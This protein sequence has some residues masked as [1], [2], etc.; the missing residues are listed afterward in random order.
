MAKIIDM[1]FLCESV[2]TRSN[3]MVMISHPKTALDR[4][5]MSP[6][7]KL[8]RISGHTVRGWLRHAAEKLLIQHGV[9]ICHPLAKISVTN[10][11]NKKYYAKDLEL[12]YHPR[13]ECKENG[14]CLLYNLFGDLDKMGNL[15]V[16]SV[17]FYPTSTGDGTATRNVNRFFKSVGGGRLEVIN[18]SPR[19]R[20]ET[21]QTYMTIEDVVGV[22]IE[23]PFRLILRN[24]NSDHEIVLLKT[25]EFLKVMVQEYN[26]D[27]M[28]GGMRN[29]GYGRAAILPL[30]PSRK[31]SKKNETSNE[32]KEEVTGQL[33]IQFALKNSEVVELNKKFEDVVNQE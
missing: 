2:T 26:I 4:K 14:G 22:M 18:S 8:G 32:S 9:S 29:S 15:M 12:G 7:A 11:R 10:D 13:G 28:L 30:K 31:I 21:H 25:L 27:F 6:Y 16:Q 3:L 17:Y 5:R 20:A 19:A 1:V 23:A 33:K 24:E